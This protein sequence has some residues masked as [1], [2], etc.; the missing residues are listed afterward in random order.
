MNRNA[1]IVLIGGRSTRMGCSKPALEWHGSTLVRRVAGIVA[2]GVGGPVVLVRSRGQSLPLLP[3]DFEVIDDLEEGRGPLGGL[4]A[5]LQALAGRGEVAYVSSSDVPFLHPAFVRRVVGE[6][7]AGLDACVP[8]VR[9]FRQPLAAAYRVSLAPLVQS[10]LASDRLR[11]SSLVEAC[12][13]KELDEAALLDNASRFKIFWK[14]LLPLTLPAQATLGIFTF[15]GSWNDYFWPLI[16]ATRKEM[17]TLTVG[18]ASVQ[19][20]FAQSEG[21]GFL[22]A[23]AVFAGLPIFIVYLFFQKYIVTAVSGAAVR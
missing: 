21:V 13:W 11:V 12:R 8:F 22:M 15:L 16:S 17:Y 20:N 7:N 3:D 1:G 19:S 23:Q 9:G 6:P 2:R 4:S 18:M 10:L 5:G 14:V